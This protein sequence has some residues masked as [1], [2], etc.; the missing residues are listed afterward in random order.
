MI[1]EMINDFGHARENVEN[2]LEKAH[3]VQSKLNSVVTFVDPTEQ[4]K[5]LD[6]HKNGFRLI[7]R[8]HSV[9]FRMLLH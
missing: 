2:A 8:P 4:L 1:K 7:E 9:L 5:N 3:E 6:Q